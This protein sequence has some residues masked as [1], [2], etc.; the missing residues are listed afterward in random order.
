MI[1]GRNIDSAMLVF[2]SATFTVNFYF[3]LKQNNHWKSI[4]LSL[5]FFSLS[6]STCCKKVNF[7]FFLQLQSNSS[8]TIWNPYLIFLFL[9]VI[10]FFFFFFL[11]L[12]VI[13]YSDTFCWR[14]LLFFFFFIM[15]W[16]C[17]VL[18]NWI[19]YISA[20]PWNIY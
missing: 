6:F 11:L 7:I 8:M 18:F 1:R 13:L 20:G 17:H 5:F 19:T 4:F 12:W 15:N 2:W 9:W 14:I 3:L 16:F 10:F